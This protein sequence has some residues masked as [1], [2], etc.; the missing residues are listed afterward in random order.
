[1]KTYTQSLDIESIV[2]DVHAIADSKLKPLA[3]QGNI[4]YGNKNYDLSQWLTIKNYAQKH[5]LKINTIS[6]W[7]TRNSIPKE[8]FVV[9]PQL[10]YLV[11][12]RDVEY[13]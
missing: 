10:N 6:N 12:I 5:H 1:M 7:I 2:A 3:L 11:L 8:N 4:Q 9:L 13:K